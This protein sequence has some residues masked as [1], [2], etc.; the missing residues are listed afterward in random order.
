MQSPSPSRIA[1]VSHPETAPRAHAVNLSGLTQSELKLMSPILCNEIAA[2]HWLSPV[3]MPKFSPS[4]VVDNMFTPSLP[5][6]T[7]SSMKPTQVS[8]SLPS[9]TVHDESPKSKRREPA[10]WASSRKA[11]V[12]DAKTVESENP[13]AHVTDRLRQIRS[14]EARRASPRSNKDLL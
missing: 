4:A 13:T 12:M 3:P 9:A 14:G 11:L 8:E 7:T 2:S 6:A 10:H 5:S 1:Y